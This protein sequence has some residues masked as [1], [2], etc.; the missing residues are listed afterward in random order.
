MTPSATPCG[1]GFAQPA[2]TTCAFGFT[3]TTTSSCTV[4]DA[5]L[6]Q[7]YAVALTL[8]LTADVAAA[9]AS[10][11]TQFGL[12]IASAAGGI[13]KPLRVTLDY[14][15]AAGRRLQSATVPTSATVLLVRA[16]TAAPGP[17]DA[18]V[19]NA[20][21]SVMV[22]MST[23]FSELRQGSA[24]RYIDATVPAA[25]TVVS[26]SDVNGA[27]PGGGSGSAVSSPGAIIGF[28]VLAF[29]VLIIAA[30]VAIGVVKRSGRRTARR[31]G[32]AARGGVLSSAATSKPET[33][34]GTRTSVLHS[35]GPADDRE[36]NME[37][38]P[39]N[40]LVFAG[41]KSPRTPSTRVL[42]V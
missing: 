42:R 16:S 25:V 30:A 23:P 34:A 4:L 41:A 26:S 14:G 22:Q 35:R 20:I 2:C 32:G 31:P 8:A 27:S 33:D 17:A 18:T 38:E 39:I 28:V 5:T 21:A 7:G 15:S 9:P 24:G 10:F 37:D 3:Q 12:D 6:T 40:P 13:V 36:V 29:A 11:E 1:I 19:N